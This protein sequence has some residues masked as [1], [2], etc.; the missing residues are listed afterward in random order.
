MAVAAGW[1][2][3]DKQNL[4]AVESLWH[5]W[6]YLSP[7]FGLLLLTIPPWAIGVILTCGTTEKKL[8]FWL[9]VG[10]AVAGGLFSFLLWF[11]LNTL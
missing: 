9:C 6:I 5:G 7:G 4:I 2:L 8:G 11:A 1:L 3:G 10:A